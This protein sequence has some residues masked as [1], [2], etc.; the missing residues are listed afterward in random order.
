MF[1]MAYSHSILAD[2]LGQ[3]PKVVAPSDLM[4]ILGLADDQPLLNRL[5]EYNHTGRPPYPSRAMWR[6]VLTKYLLGIRYNVELVATLRSN[7]A[8]RECCGSG[9]SRY[10]LVDLARYASPVM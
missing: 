7:A 4:A 8:I 6:A 3:V 2:V 1:L 5:D 9:Q 10:R